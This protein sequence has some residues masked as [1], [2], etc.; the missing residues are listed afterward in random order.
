MYS[1]PH[2]WQA[3]IPRCRHLLVGISCRLAK[4]S[5]S[6]HQSHEMPP[7]FVKPSHRSSIIAPHPSLCHAPHVTKSSW[8]RWRGRR[9]VRIVCTDENL[10]E[11]SGCHSPGE[12]CL[13]QLPIRILL[14]TR[15]KTGIADDLDKATPEL[16]SRTL[17]QTSRDQR[18]NRLWKATFF[19]DPNRYHSWDCVPPLRNLFRGNMLCVWSPTLRVG[20]TPILFLIPIKKRMGGRGFR[21]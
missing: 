13:K 5:S 3:K 19:V 2:R 18:A 17:F 20:T 1:R 4:P 7:E 12:R 9:L 16:V 8:F 6:L 11:V 21:I 14:P 10:V 15:Q